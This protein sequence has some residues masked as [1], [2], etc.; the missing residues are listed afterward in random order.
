MRRQR[1]I[2]LTQL[3][4]AGCAIG[5]FSYFGLK[6]YPL[7]Y[8]QYVTDAAARKIFYQEGMEKKTPVILY[9][10]FARQASLDG[11]DYFP[12]I[13]RKERMRITNPIKKTD[14]KTVTI[15]YTKETL[16]YGSMHLTLKYN[17]TFALGTGGDK[18]EAALN[19]PSL[20]K[21]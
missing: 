8:A 7:T 9:K 3:M 6:A 13:S 12:K 21:K 16:L 5:A 4:V 1:G 14:K 2:S 15:F 11:A 10:T 18:F 19:R 20:D 17:R